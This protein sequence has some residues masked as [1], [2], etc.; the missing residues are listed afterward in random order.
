MKKEIVDAFNKLA[1][2]YEHTIDENSPYN[3]HYER[4]AM[5]AQLPDVMDGK[6]VLDAGCAAGWYTEQLL[7]K[8]ADVVA[9]DVSEEM[10][11][12][13][14]RRIGTESNVLCLNLQEKLP[15][16]NE[17]FDYIV[18][19][20]T[21]HYLDCWEDTMM[22]FSR[23]M[24]PGGKLLFS[25]H[26]PFMEYKFSKTGDYF[27]RERLVLPWEK[28]KAGTVYVPFYR[29]SLQETIASPSRYFSIEKI[30]EPQPIEQLIQL[31]KQTYEKL[32]TKPQFLIVI[33]EK[34]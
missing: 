28:P 2:D 10:V 11:A 31:H 14:K 26:H 34:K 27:T 5:L 15:F 21:L 9:I 7:K 8:G 30:I 6:K 25:V 3:T 18:S 4:P 12:A 32:M 16:A 13:T 20:L 1:V 33:C 22:E 29:R 24:K 17:H 19:S 23:V